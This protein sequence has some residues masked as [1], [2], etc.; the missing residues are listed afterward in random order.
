MQIKLITKKAEKKTVENFA[1]KEWRR[2]NRELAYGW[3]TKKYVFAAYEGKKVVG[4]ASLK[5]N[6]GAAYLS[7]LIVS[8][9]MRS[10]GIGDML[11]RKFEALAK[12]KKCH[13]AYLETS[14]KHKEAL[15]FYKKRGY[16]LIA[17][18]D[19]NKFHLT[20]YFLGKNIA[21]GK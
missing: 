21:Y 2:F 19:N 18:M 13:I 15:T 20:W 10:K 12:S 8:N 7:Q 5:I 16:K 1:H 17:K 6:G 11:L 3:N 14:E 4:F 9:S